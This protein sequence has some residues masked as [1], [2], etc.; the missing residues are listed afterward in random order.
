M[1]RLCKADLTLF[2]VTSTRTPLLNFR[3]IR[4]V[5][6]IAAPICA[7]VIVV[8][9]SV[10]MSL[11]QEPLNA[12]VIRDAKAAQEGIIE[13]R[14]PASGTLFTRGPVTLRTNVMYRFMKAEGLPSGIKEVDTDI[15]TIAPTFSLDFGR[16]WSVSYDP[17]WTY[18]SSPEFEDT[19][20]QSVAIHGG[21]IGV[22]WLLML[23]QSFSLASPTLYETGQQTQQKTWT[24]AV[25]ASR[26]IGSRYSLQLN[27]H[28]AG[29]QSDFGNDSRDWST[30]DWF[31]VQI[32]PGLNAG[33]GPTFGYVDISDAP[34]MTYQRFMGR[35]S[36]NPTNKLFFNA[37]GGVE[38]RQ[39]NSS[40]AKDIENPIVSMTTTYHPF[41]TTSLSLSFD[42]TVNTSLY[43]NQV[44]VGATWRLHFEQR[45][46]RRF[47]FS[48]DWSRAENEYQATT[49]FDPAAPPT[50]PS[51]PGR[52]DDIDEFSCR[53][54]TQLFKRLSIAAT[55]QDTSNQS[56][57]G[58][59]DTS[60]RQYGIELNCRF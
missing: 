47:Y 25:S 52:K 20:D 13:S 18:Y 41:E 42:H 27:G 60:T 3:R 56:N 2:P 12:P 21:M 44:T 15:Q 57:Q 40:L 7:G 6:A 50:L 24:T 49:E 22:H 5:F 58:L 35:L 36:F 48:A 34:D 51:L 11:P 31:M 37:S 53:L 8:G 17:S 19:F 4:A 1:R 38:R 54:T 55:Y 39:T 45:L 16:H 10:I 32:S 28:V 33:V 23:D 26:S 30:D 43:D 46:L 14:P 9:Q 29:L 59:F